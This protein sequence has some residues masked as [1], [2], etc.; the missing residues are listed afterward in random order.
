RWPS[1]V[2]LVLL[3]L[4]G[5]LIIVL[6]FVAPGIVKEYAEQAIVV[7]PR[8][9]SIDSFTAS[10]VR[11]RIQASVCLDSRRVS[12]DPVRNLG[13]FFTYLAAEVETGES[14]VE[15]SLPEYGNVVLG[16]AQ[17]PPIK[18]SIRDGQWKFIDILVDVRPGQVDG[19]RSIANDWIDGR[20][21]RLRVLAKAQVPL[22]S[23]LINVGRQDIRQELMLS[24]GKIPKMP[25]YKLKDVS[26]HE[27]DGPNGNSSAVAVD[28]SLGVMNDYP[29]E[30]T[31]PPLEFDILVDAC[32]E[33][34]PNIV[35]ARARTH[36]LNVKPE[37]LL[38]AR[39]TATMHHL[40]ASLIRDCPNAGDSP[41]DRLVGN[42]LHGKNTTIYIRGSPSLSS[43][44]SS[45][46]EQLPAPESEAPEWLT[47]LL[48]SLTLPIPIPPPS[49]DKNPLIRNFSLTNTHF[50][51]PDPW[52]EDPN[53]PEAKPRISADVRALVALPPPIALNLK[54]FD[55][56]R[57][58]AD[59]DVLYN[60]TKFAELDLSAWQR[61]NLTHLSTKKSQ[62]TLLLIQSHID[63]AP[64]IITNE[65]IFTKVVEKLIFGGKGSI[66]HLQ[67]VAQVDV[68]VVTSLGDVVVR[69]LPA[70]G[71]VPL[72]Q[73]AP[74]PPRHQLP[75]KT[76]LTL[77]NPHLTDLRLHSSTR[78]S[79][80]L[81][82]IFGFTNPT[83]YS[84]QI[85]YFSAEF[86]SSGHLLGGIT[87][88]RNTS[89]TEGRNE[90]VGVSV[91]YAPLLQQHRAGISAEDEGR[92][93]RDEGRAFLGKFISGGKEDLVLGVRGSPR[94]FI[95][96]GSPA[97]RNDKIRIPRGLLKIGGGG[98]GMQD[99]DDTNEGDDGG[100]DDGL[101]FIQDATFHLFSSS[102]TTNTAVPPKPT[103]TLHPIAHIFYSDPLTI[104]PPAKRPLDPPDDDDGIP[105]WTTPKLP[106]EWSLGSVGYEAVRKALGG[107]LKVGARAEI[108]VGIGEWREQKVVFEREGGIGAKVRL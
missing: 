48:S 78:T 55:V 87:L 106:V 91:E 19:L 73:S 57:V 67:I 62:P 42:Y 5:I 2:A 41:L 52:A 72:K 53:S 28:A 90:D 18:M 79:L 35:V 46:S 16:T 27:V 81:A 11:T 97:A 33:N 4:G 13:R 29:V 94:T 84:A 45:S 26:V 89:V 39:V 44:E 10:G 54:N 47:G 7:E 23:G 96:E 51:L 66:V 17:V 69:K 6:A 9:L 43:I 101:H 83:P 60:G 100:D 95:P 37:Q 75:P 38:D 63:Q 1:L 103:T 8:S 36:E 20:L 22:S 92:K 93:A 25:A 104:P 34:D 40:P 85:P 12:Q 30:F 61:A 14:D 77:L 68:E 59:A 58:R 56:D 65:D 105:G 82:A 71:D 98:G 107:S 102:A 24:N 76:N 50:D 80:V 86:L 21:G 99:D 64:L 31:V 70:H 74:Q 88:G 15:V 32:A 3:I 108:D 49:L